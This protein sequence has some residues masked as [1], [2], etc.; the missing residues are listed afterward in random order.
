MDMIVELSLPAVCGDQPGSADPLGVAQFPSRAP[1]VRLP[2]WGVGGSGGVCAS[3]GVQGE[4]WK[5]V[6]VILSRSIVSVRGH[7]GRHGRCRSE[8]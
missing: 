8:N 7:H 4:M 1:G 2:G 5:R 3:G 6:M